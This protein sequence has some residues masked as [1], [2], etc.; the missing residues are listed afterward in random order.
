MRT[1]DDTSAEAAE[2]RP[3]SSLHRGL[4]VLEVVAQSG[5]KGASVTEVATRLELDKSTAS[6]TLSTLRAIGYVQQDRTRRYF[7][8]SKLAKLAV[9]RP[10]G[11]DLVAL[12]RER[13]EQLHRQVDEAIHLAIADGGEMLF[14]DYMQTSKVV[15]S[16][17][18]TTPRPLHEVAVGIAVLAALD[19]E[20]RVQELIEAS[21]NVGTAP[22]STE[23]H[24]ALSL[25]ISRARR[26]GWA[27]LDRGDD[28]SR[29]AVAIRDRAGAPI[30]ALCVYGP[31]YRLDPIQDTIVQA[32]QAAAADLSTA[33]DA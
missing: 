14:L 10:G 30:A 5:S 1:S 32:A 8:T 28:V 6:R 33:L 11:S 29:V 15:R 27:T 9:R 31:S 16:E 20:D 7:S 3:S 2:A 18:S 17:E 13:L 22:L 23:D 25:E 24:Q 19:D 21:E 4:Q 12:A 26:R